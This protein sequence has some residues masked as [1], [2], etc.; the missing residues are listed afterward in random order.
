M[1]IHRHDARRVS[2]PN[3]RQIHRA[4]VLADIAGGIPLFGIRRHIQQRRGIQIFAQPFRPAV[5]FVI[6][7]YKL[8]R[9]IHEHQSGNIGLTGIDF[10]RAETAARR[11]FLQL[12]GNL[13]GALDHAHQALRFVGQIDAVVSVALLLHILG[14]RHHHLM[15]RFPI[16]VRGRQKHAD[17]QHQ[18]QQNLNMENA[19][20][21]P[22][23]F[24]FH[25]SPPPHISARLI[26]IL[27]NDL[28]HRP[29]FPHFL[30]HGGKRLF[31]P[32]LVF[33]RK[34]DA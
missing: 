12:M 26:Q 7:L 28:L 20:G 6:C 2:A 17:R 19:D 3:S 34:R 18:T 1:V 4:S 8:P 33:L 14:R 13:F 24:A 5:G 22:V 16:Q 29:I 25:R 11:V 23:S 27:P 15:G 10:R 32:P 31:Q 21:N 9:F 30:K